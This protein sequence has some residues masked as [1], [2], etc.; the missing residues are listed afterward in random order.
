MSNMKILFTKGLINSNLFFC[1]TFDM[2]LWGG[3]RFVH[4]LGFCG[5]T[6]A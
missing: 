4:V 5:I 2:C 1:S 6:I 3:L